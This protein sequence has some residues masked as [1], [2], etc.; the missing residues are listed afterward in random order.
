MA[1]AAPLGPF[2]RTSAIAQLIAY[3]ELSDD[4]E[5]A[6]QL[7]A[8]IAALAP[9]SGATLQADERLPARSARGH[10]L[11]L[12]STMADGPL[13]E[14]FERIASALEQWTGDDPT[15][16]A[17]LGQVLEFRPRRLEVC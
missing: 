12:T 16:K 6:D 13:R 10:L 5:L 8:A 11:A 7:D 15:G 3:R 17:P 9:A 4:G 1:T 2:I 14:D